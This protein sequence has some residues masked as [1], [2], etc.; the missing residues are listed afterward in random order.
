MFIPP[1]VSLCAALRELDFLSAKEV[2]PGC[3]NE[4]TSSN[5]VKDDAADPE[6][7]PQSPLARN[8]PPQE[9]EEAPAAPAQN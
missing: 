9:D 4:D 5:P 8:A 3:S 6:S 2:V 1:F 7:S